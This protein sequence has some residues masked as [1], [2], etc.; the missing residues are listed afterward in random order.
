MRKNKASQEPVQQTQSLSMWKGLDV[1]GLSR[2]PPLHCAA[3][4]RLDGVGDEDD[5]D[6][7][8]IVG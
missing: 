7:V 3:F 6:D 8:E 1:L 5:D 2:P 4:L